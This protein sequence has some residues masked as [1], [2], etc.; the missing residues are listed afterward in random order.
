MRTS[1]FV[2]PDKNSEM[3]AAFKAIAEKLKALGK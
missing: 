1:A 3:S 2:Q